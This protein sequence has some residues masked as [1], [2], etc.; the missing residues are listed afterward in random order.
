MINELIQTGIM[1]IIRHNAFFNVSEL[2][3]ALLEAECTVIEITLNSFKAFNRITEAAKEFQGKI[4]LGAGTVLSVN[5]AKSALDSGATYIVSPVLNLEL[6]DFCVKQNVSVFPGVATPTEAYNAFSAGASMVKL[7]PAGSFGPEYVKAIKGPLSNLKVLAV[8]GVS[9]SN[10]AD[11]FSNGA[12]AVAFGA[13]IVKPEYLDE[14][15]YDAIKDGVIDLLQA[16]NRARA[17]NQLI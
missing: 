7:F 17:N 15:N 11:Y 1:A 5:D 6:I 3:N 10:V 9:V 14:H 4:E 8:G 12:D 2:F 16:V 13:S